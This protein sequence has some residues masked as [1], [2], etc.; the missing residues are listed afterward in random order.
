MVGR[1]IRELRKQR[2]LSQ[3]EISKKAGIARP[4]LSRVENNHSQPTVEVLEALADAMDVDVREFFAS[5]G[6]TWGHDETRGSEKTVPIFD[7]GV[8]RDVCAAIFQNV[9]D[10]E[11][12]AGEGEAHE[13]AFTRDPNAFYVVARGA[14]M[15]GGGG[16]RSIEEG[17]LLLVEPNRTVRDGDIVLCRRRGGE[18]PEVLVKMF[19][20][21]GGNGVALVALNHEYAPVVMNAQEAAESTF[22]RVTEI[23]RRL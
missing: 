6:E 4:Y 7:P 13:P 9:S 16:R 10:G 5:V 21:I 12:P 2:K 18:G 23:K 3:D 20:K 14:S 19:K 17:D 1:R 22:Y 15:T 11:R 8:G